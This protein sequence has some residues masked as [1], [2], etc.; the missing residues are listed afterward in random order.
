MRASRW[1]VGTFLSG[2]LVVALLLAVTLSTPPFV[3]DLT[4]IGLLSEREFGW[5]E[6][7]LGVDARLL[8]STSLAQSDLVVV[9]DSF[10]VGLVWQS[11]LV[12]AGVRVSTLQWDQLGGALCADF[13]S[14]LQQRGF[15][16]QRLI[17]QSV[18]RELVGRV[19]LSRACA[20]QS[21]QIRASA[22]KA[23][24]VPM[25]GD[26]YT[27]EAPLMTPPS[28]R[29]NWGEKLLTGVYT[30]VNGWRVQ[31]RSEVL[32]GESSSSDHVR[33]RTLPQGCLWFSHRQCA[34]GLFLAADLAL[35]QFDAAALAQLRT[36]AGRD[37]GL[38]VMW[39]IV[40]NKSSLYLQEA[41]SAWATLG[42]SGL[43]PDVLAMLRLSLGDVQDLYLPNDTHLSPRGYLLL[44][45]L[46]KQALGK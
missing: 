38:P 31:Q 26:A 34:Q 17:V 16:G 18:E 24:A 46:V 21:E 25:H 35:P 6:P 28:M 36:L 10:S 39:L 19:S 29:L 4:R 9:G 2:V 8:R 43:G 5:R 3:G 20:S 40:P 12:Q 11:V 41:T 13:A 42:G 1:W 33:V 44:G 15:R 30:R 45:A 7:Q 23:G 22:G 14:W 37:M 32:V 27:R